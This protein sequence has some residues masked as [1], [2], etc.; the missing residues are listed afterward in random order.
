MVKDLFSQDAAFSGRMEIP[1]IDIYSNGK[2]HGIINTEGEHWEQLRRF[3]LRQLRDFGFG[4]KSMEGLI[5]EELKEIV[6]WMKSK[7]GFPV[8]DIKGKMT[9][10]VINS[11]WTILSGHRYK[12]D[13]PVLL[14]LTKNINQ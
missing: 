2:M 13:D 10:A 8:E 11:L 6:E 9:I 12:H 14:A 1:I 5:M 7:E 3:T 4:K